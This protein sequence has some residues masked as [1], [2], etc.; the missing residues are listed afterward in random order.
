M[1]GL[2]IALIRT[3]MQGEREPSRQSM[4]SEI[5]EGLR[6]VWHH[7]FMRG[8]AVAAVIVQRVSRSVD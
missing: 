8:L 7:D 6:F 3:P 4:R 2:L 1:G 5:V